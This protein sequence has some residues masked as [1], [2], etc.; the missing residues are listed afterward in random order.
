M[1]NVGCQYQNKL[2]NVGTVSDD[3]Y[4]RKFPHFS[5]HVLLYIQGKRAI[6]YLDAA[7]HVP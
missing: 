2:F 1:I 7:K 5:Q 3:D 4:E 6:V